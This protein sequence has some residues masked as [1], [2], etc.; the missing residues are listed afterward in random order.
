LE[1][2][3]KLTYNLVLIQKE[4]ASAKKSIKLKKELLKSAKIAF[5]NQAMT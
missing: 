5:S 1:E 2:V 3:N 4:I